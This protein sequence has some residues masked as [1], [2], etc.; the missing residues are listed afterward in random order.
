MIKQALELLLQETQMEYGTANIQIK[1]HNKEI[2]QIQ[3]PFEKVYKI[4]NTNPDCIMDFVRE[5]LDQFYIEGKTGTI[6]F[7]IQFKNGVP[8]R[9]KEQGFFIKT[10]DTY[11]PKRDELDDRI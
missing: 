8:K 7:S 4:D 6:D 1:M 3:V 5:I 9:L 11:T 2:G 10:Y